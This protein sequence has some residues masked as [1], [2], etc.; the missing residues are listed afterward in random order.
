MDSCAVFWRSDV[1]VGEPVA[2][3]LSV[4]SRTALSLRSLTFTSL[5]IHMSGEMPT[6]IVRN[7]AVDPFAELLPVQHVDL[8]HITPQD[9]D[10]RDVEGPLRFGVGGTIVF[11]GTVSCEVPATVKVEDI[12][13]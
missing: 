5:V 3:Q 1:L 2:F 12:H 6:L 13:V 8:G 10:D 9:G 7:S 11:C 4:T